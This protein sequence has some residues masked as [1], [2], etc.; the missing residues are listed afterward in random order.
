MRSDGFERMD[1]STSI[2]DDPKF[3][4]LARRHPETFATA[5]AAYVGLLAR[6]WREGERLTLEEGWPALLQIDEKAICAMREV[7]LVDDEDRLPQGA[8][9]AW[10]GAAV[11]R[12]RLGRE[13]Q[14]RA[15]VRRGRVKPPAPPSQSIS[16]S[17][18]RADRPSVSQSGPTLVHGRSNAGLCPV[19][20]KLMRHDQS[21]TVS[22]LGS[23]ALEMHSSC[24][25]DAAESA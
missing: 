21:T 9:T 8:W 5:L 20:Q 7:E 14:H 12:R 13:R 19:C 16:Q 18:G 3:R 24:I 25:P 2:D 10:Y 17:E 11:E 22:T 6:S 23:E 4:A 1:V 15:D